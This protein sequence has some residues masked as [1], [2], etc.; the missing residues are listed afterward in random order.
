MV[1]AAYETDWQYLSEDHEKIDK[2]LSKII[3]DYVANHLK[4]FSYA[5]I[6]TF[7]VGKT[8]LLYQIHKNAK[9]NGLLPL[10]FI[11]EDLFREVISNEDKVFTPGDIFTLV[12][13]KVETI[14][15]ALST[16]NDGNVKKILDPR[17]KLQT[18]APELVDSIIK[19]FSGFDVSNL[20]VVLLID[21][22]EGQYGVLQ[23]N[24]Q[25]KDRSP[26]REFLENK[27]HL[28]FLAFAPAGIY[29]L[30]GAD[31]DRV[32]RIVI[33]PADIG[34]I[35][36]ELITNPGKSNACWWLSRGKA[37][38][39]YKACEVLKEIA[40]PI[41]A[42][43]ASRI[44]KSQLDSIGQRPTEVPPAVTSA[45]DPSK[46]PY[47]L[48]LFPIESELRR[49]YVIDTANLKTGE[50]ANRLIEAF[51]IN[52]DNAVLI[53]EYF[54]RTVKTLSDE[55]G[56]TYI[57]D[58]DLS[59]LFCLAFDHLLE[60]E[61]GS[62][63]LSGNLG[64]IL[65]LYEK[66]K[67]DDAALYGI[68]GR[69]WELKETKWQLPLTIEEI[70]KAF[71][72]PTM[73]PIVKNNIPIEMKKKWEGKGLPI[74]K[75]AEGDIT[76]LFFASERDLTNY[77]D[78]DEFISL[79]LPDGKG[80]L[81]LLSTGEKFKN[82]RPFLVWL[83][84]NNK[85]QFFELPPLLT[86]FLLSASGEIQGDLPG[87]LQSHLRDFKDN[88]EDVLLS[89][90]A[91]IY[92]EGINENIRASL[93]KPETFYKGALPDTGTVWGKGQMDRN[94]A[95]NGIAMAFM[96]L[97]TQERQHLVNIRDLFK[98]G[99]EGSGNGDLNPLIPRVG[100]I[101]LCDDLLPRYGKK[102]D[103]KDSEPVGRLKGYWRDE[104]NELIELSRILPCEDFL[105]LHPDED[106]SR[107]LEALWKT[108][109]RD[110][111]YKDIEALI[112]KY[113]KNFYPVLENCWRLEQ[114]AI[115]SFSLNGIS[116]LDKEKL[117]K[118]KDGV[119]K[120]SEI[121]R[122]TMK[123]TGSAAPF[124]KS[125][126]KT[127]MN[128][129][130][131]NIEKDVRNLSFSSSNAKITLDEF[132]IAS[133]NLTKNFWEY[134]KGTKFAG[135]TEENIKT[136]VS[137]Q[138]NIGGNLTLKELETTAK[139]KTEFLEDISKNLNDLEKKLNILSDIF[140]QIKED[141]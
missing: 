95:I 78:T 31:R 91:E 35:R 73:N 38:Q 102:K 7:G 9:S 60:Y 51:G 11:A 72:F 77:S 98:S 10:Y 106:M 69:L 36:K 56:I 29:E 113:D 85:L 8:Q 105:K 70:R 128:V 23:S 71:P 129:M 61:H 12:V 24:I 83:K 28:K 139:E 15:V 133:V 1:I 135:I 45:V 5:V 101:A 40:S 2:S 100:Y 79:V 89:R 55:G 81:C 3:D 126:V 19:D 52:K 94:V 54:K 65:N 32:K 84:K 110:F 50:L 17:G 109:R 57:E 96:D 123:D 74:W 43:V 22:L 21:E 64:E 132:K 39:L 86:D 27:N 41:E 120:L 47:L 68:I 116:F 44:I 118:A 112:Q 63:E 136:I 4:H 141:A 20:K 75:C 6:G 37:R 30:G 26:L 107:L 103:L 140:N 122:E 114:E 119:K 93:P 134:P 14:K 67:K 46:I 49:R 34:Y 53:S 117:I 138:M 92:T 104:R 66:I 58:T 80:V 90:K 137:E 16:K 48:D 125:I 82:E 115:A 18:D 87:D 97:T 76:V 130:A 59:E 111:D 13:G 99:R 88:N 33:P 131:E 127:F 42:D 25:T 62:P 108:V 124:I 121:A